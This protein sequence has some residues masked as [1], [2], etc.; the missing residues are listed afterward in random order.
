MQAVEWG[1]ERVVVC[2]C[3]GGLESVEYGTR[4]SQ[5]LGSIAPQIFMDRTATEGRLT[6]GGQQAARWVVFADIHPS[7][8][9][10]DAH[11]VITA[12]TKGCTIALCLMS[13]YVTYS[14][15][16]SLWTNECDCTGAVLFTDPLHDGNVHIVS[17]NPTYSGRTGD[18]KWLQN[19]C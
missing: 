13:P 17:V 5:E 14:L 2:G 15:R 3:L 10:V 6:T 1:L 8:V 11:T 12:T 19:T 4:E 18:G 7:G 9:A 16:F